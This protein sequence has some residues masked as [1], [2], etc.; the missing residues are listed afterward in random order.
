[1]K[2]FLRTDSLVAAIEKVSLQQ[3]IV[4][5]PSPRVGAFKHDHD[6]T[7]LSFS[8]KLDFQAMKRQRENG[9]FEKTTNLINNN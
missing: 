1:M 9:F 2:A 8:Y 7:A 4:E 3:S 6:R 5:Q